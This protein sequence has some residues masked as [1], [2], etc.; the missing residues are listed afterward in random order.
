MSPSPATKALESATSIA[1]KARDLAPRGLADAESAAQAA[2]ERMSLPI[3]L[4]MFGFVVFLGY[5]AV[6]QVLNGL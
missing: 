2:S 3:V 4:L 6:M 5:P 1:A